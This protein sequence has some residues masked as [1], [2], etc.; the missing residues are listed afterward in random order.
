MPKLILQ[1]HLPQLTPSWNSYYWYFGFP[2]PALFFILLFSY[3][4]HRFLIFFWLSFEFLACVAFYLLYTVFFTFPPLLSISIACCNI[5]IIA[6][7]YFINPIAPR[8][9]FQYNLEVFFHITLLKMGFCSDSSDWYPLLTAESFHMNNNSLFVQPHRGQPSYNIFN[10]LS[11]VPVQICQTQ[12]RGEEN[13]CH[14]CSWVQ[15]YL[16]I[17]AMKEMEGKGSL[18]HRSFFVVFAGHSGHSGPPLGS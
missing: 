3:I 4:I 16:S 18:L 14:C 11:L 5:F 12:I 8:V 7:A 6:D 10:G 17:G 15:I 9:S 1:W 2:I 13:N